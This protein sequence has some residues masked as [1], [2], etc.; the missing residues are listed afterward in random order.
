MHDRGHFGIR[1]KF[2]SAELRIYKIYIIV[3]VTYEQSLS[4]L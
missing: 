2:M 4:K 1:K 3:Q